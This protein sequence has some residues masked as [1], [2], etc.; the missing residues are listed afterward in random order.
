MTMLLFL[1]VVCLTLSEHDFCATVLEE[2]RSDGP[3]DPLPGR[4]VHPGPLQGGARRGDH[5][6]AEFHLEAATQEKL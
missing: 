2:P 4:A 3:A 5:P 1:A 6:A